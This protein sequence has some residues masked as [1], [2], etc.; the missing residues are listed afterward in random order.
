MCVVNDFSARFPRLFNEE[1]RVFSV[2]DAFTTWLMH[3]KRLDFYLISYT[4]IN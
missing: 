1:G 2:T 3:K 4:K